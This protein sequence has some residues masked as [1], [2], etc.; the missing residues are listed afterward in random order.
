M[1]FARPA[2]AVCLLAISAACGGNSTPAPAA[3][4]APAVDP[5]T[6]GTV[7]AIVKFDGAVPVP[8]MQRLEGDPK[9]V[10]ENGAPERAD[11]SLMVG[12]DQALQ[13]V[14]VYVKAG[15]NAYGFPVPAEP[16]VLDQDKCRYT[17]RVLGVRVGQPLSVRNSDPLLH[18][19]RANG[20]INQGFNMS[21]PVEGVSFERTFATS[22]VMVPFKCDVHA[23]MSAYVGVLD[24]PYFGTTAAD[25]KVVLA[26]LPPGTYT[27]EAW[28]ETLGTRTEQVTIA[29]KESKDVAFTF[30]R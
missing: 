3:T 9:C 25:G 1:Y 16:V 24:H 28:H 20:Q 7:T 12:S 2:V 14:F 8:A 19:V 15:L 26:N 17:P 5:A 18:N 6:A 10:T 29:A 30:T 22:E 21:T 13:N 23:W 11:E 27:I 4:A